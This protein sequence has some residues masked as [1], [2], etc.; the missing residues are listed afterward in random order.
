MGL[1]QP[2]CGGRNGGEG[3]G[4]HRMPETE[5]RHRRGVGTE[6]AGEEGF[7]PSNAGI[8]IRCLNQLGDSPAE[9]LRTLSTCARYRHGTRSEQFTR[10]TPS[11]C[12]AS[13]RA[14]KPRIAGGQR[15][16]RR[17]GPRPRWRTPRTRT[18]P[19]P[20]SAR[21][22]S[23]C[24]KRASASA[25]ARKPRRRRRS[26]DRSGRNPRKRR[27]FSPTASFVS[28]PALRKSPRSRTCTGR[29]RH[30][31]P[32][33]RQRHRRQALADAPR[34]CAARRQEERNVGAQR[35]ADAA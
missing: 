20:S 8:K 3:R 16:Q 21:A 14:T 25:T 9:N 31:E 33:R 22:A 23:A 17:A 5:G 29:H 2:G 24:R 12:R 13:V 7:E 11:G 6:M 34:E 26:A 35:H 18:R 10:M 19:I 28:I 30:R 32:Q 1:C 27:L 4:A 15:R